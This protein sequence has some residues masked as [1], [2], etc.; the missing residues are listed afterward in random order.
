MAVQ[1]LFFMVILGQ[2]LGQEYGTQNCLALDWDR[3]KD[4]KDTSG[5]FNQEFITEPLTVTT[6]PQQL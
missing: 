6:I 1:K 5:E 4:S 3:E 2:C